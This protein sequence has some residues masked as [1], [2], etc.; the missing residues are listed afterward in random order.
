MKDK[1]ENKTQLATRLS[2]VYLVTKCTYL[3]INLIVSIY[4]DANIFSRKMVRMEGK[5]ANHQLMQ[6]TNAKLYFT[7][8]HV[9]CGLHFVI[10]RAL[11]HSHTCTKAT[12]D[13]KS[14]L[15]QPSLSSVELSFSDRILRSK[16]LLSLHFLIDKL[17]YFNRATIQT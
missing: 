2:N 8:R 7:G 6:D 14:S 16:I 13:T 15:S 12:D 10:I 17:D 9:F 5:E 1:Q 4:Q 11:A 3:D